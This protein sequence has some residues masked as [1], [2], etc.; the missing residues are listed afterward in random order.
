MLRKYEN[1]VKNIGGHFEIGLS[2]KKDDVT[3]PNNYSNALS[4]LVKLERKFKLDTDLKKEYVNFISKDFEDR[5]A[6][7]LKSQDI[8][9]NPGKTW[10]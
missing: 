5:N 1:S 7:Q 3:L 10:Y 2:L 9:N 4:H 6:V 8:E